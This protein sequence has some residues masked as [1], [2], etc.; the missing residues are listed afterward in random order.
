MKNLKL[1][2]L[3]VFVLVNLQSFAIE[4]DYGPDW[5]VKIDQ[6][7]ST[8][9]SG[10]TT[11]KLT[12]YPIEA[13]VEYK[14]LDQGDFK[15]LKRSQ[16]KEFVILDLDSGTYHFRISSPAY[17]TVEHYAEFIS[18]HY[19]EAQ[20]QLRYPRKM[21]TRKPA[22]YLYGEPGLNMSLKVNPV[23]EFN[24]VHP[25]MSDQQWNIELGEAG[26]II[27]DNKSYDYLFWEGQQDEI[28]IDRTNGFVVNDQEAIAFLEEK[29]SDLG[30]NDKELNDFL[31]YWGPEL[32]KHK[33]NFIHFVVNDDYEQHIASLNSSVPI[34]TSIRIFMFH[35]PC[36]A[37]KVVTPQALTSLTRKGLTLVEWGGGTYDKK[38]PKL[39]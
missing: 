23:G 30:L 27:L 11:V 22:I 12:V 17:Y 31:V 4:V 28:Y 7:D 32:I 36:D 37:Y 20:V 26:K 15:K 13:I 5:Q 2:Y 8:V 6:I 38:K 10:R 34:E 39:N 24:F 25:K 18:Q 3:F 29:L 9:K 19:Y 35:E 16:K 14:L 1:I 33:H 21:Q